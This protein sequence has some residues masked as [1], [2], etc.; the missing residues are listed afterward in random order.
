MVLGVALLA[1]PLLALAHAPDPKEEEQIVRSIVAACPGQRALAERASSEF[2]GTERQAALVHYEG[3]AR[4]ARTVAIVHVRIGFL[5][6]EAGD[7]ASAEARYR[8]A[9]ALDPRFTNRLSLLE[10][11][12][13]QNKPEA[14]PLYAELARYDGDRDDIWA[15]LSYV[16]FHR[17]DVAFMR[18]ASARAIALD[19]RWWQPWFTAAVAEGLAER[20][21]YPRALGQLDRAN[22]LGGPPK[23]I[24]SMRATL[25]EA[26]GRRAR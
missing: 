7:F 6:F 16:A 24:E 15:A 14:G 4:C 12:T 9:V 26:A 20:P 11:L 3:L 17:D 8:K 5:K 18:K 23:I 19:T 1:V 21:D 2:H 25:Q 22:A 10:A 13:R